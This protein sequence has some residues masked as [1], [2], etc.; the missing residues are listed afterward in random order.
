VATPETATGL[1]EG[2]ARTALGGLALEELELLPGIPWDRGMTAAWVPSRSAAEA[3]LE[4]FVATD[5]RRYAAGR[6][7]PAE[8]WVSRLSPYLH[9][10]QLGPREVVAACPTGGEAADFLR[11]LGWREFAHHLLYHF[12][13]TSDAPLDQRFDGFPWR[14]DEAQ[15][16]AWQR[17]ET[18]IPLIDAGMRQLWDTGWMHNR[19]RMIVASFLTKNLLLP[20]QAG[21][22]WFWDTLVDA[23]LASNTLGWQWTAGC[24]ADA[25]PYFRVFNPVLQGEKFDPEGEYVRRWV[26]TL[27]GLPAKWVHRPWQ[28]PPEVLASAGVKLG[29]DYPQPLVD[30]KATRSRALEAWGRIR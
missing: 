9:F 26:P 5:L 16:H 14:D 19:V 8:E 18:G 21:A 4:E 22:R 1:V 24:G 30:L 7:L 17:G 29:D 10:G 15:L 20:W 3:R 2:E 27:A 11:E 13:H 25:A 12:P 23:D 6:D 28:A